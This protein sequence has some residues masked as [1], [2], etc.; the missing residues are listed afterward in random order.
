MKSAKAASPRRHTVQELAI[1]CAILAACVWTLAAQDAL[2]LARLRDSHAYR[3][4]S[5]NPDPTSNDDS[6]RPIPGE[7]IVL[8]DVQG[9][10]VI[11]HIWLTIAANEYGWPRLLRLRAYYDGS[12]TP[13]VDVPVGDFFAVGHGYEREVKSLMI[14][15]GSA[16]RARNSYWPMPFRRSC[17]ITITNEGRRR[18]SN[19]YYHV[20]WEKRKQMPAD[21]GYFHAW[22]KQEIPA[23]MGR[24][25]EVLSVRGRGQYVG[26]LLNVI[27]TQP[28][29]FGEGD[30]R[31]Y[32]D[33]EKKPSIEGTG[34]EDYFNDAWS[35]RVS[36]GPYWGVP[37]AEGTGP[38]ARMTAYRWHLRDPIPFQR[39][40][41][42][43][44]EHAGWT[45]NSNGSVKSAFEER[46]DIFSSVAFW[47][48]DG[49]GQV[50]PEPPYGS[51]RLPHGNALQIEAES[52]I[53]AVKTEG[54]KAEVQKDVFWSRDLLF[55]HATGAG[56]RIDVPIDVADD[57]FFEI[58]AQVAHAPDYGDYRVLLDGATL[59][60]E[61]DLEN[62]PGANTGSGSLIQAWGPEIYVAQDHLLGW[63]KLSKGTHTLAFVCAGKDVRSSGF[64]LGIDT[65]ILAKIGAPIDVVAPHVP[66]DLPGLI[67]TLSNPDAVF[68]GMAALALR[69]MGPAARPALKALA[70]ALRDPDTGVRMTAADAIARQGHEAVAVLDDLIA[71]AKVQGENVHVQRS[72]AMAFG[73]IGPAA[74]PAVPVLHDL[75]KI[76]RVTPTAATAIRQITGTQ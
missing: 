38:G 69:D 65:F 47:Y 50:L 10:G 62:E 12:A 24:P 37:V 1:G 72:L 54:G 25:Y 73:A 16:G 70:A 40:L 35:L 13:S 32:I 56:S 8:A 52:N 57:G 46:P 58:V 28:G 17:K 11:T 22:Y 9:P 7:T 34:T 43:D 63:R 44:F 39:S 26:T 67:V 66:S 27:Q 59:A 23:K 53:E 60:P 48:Q 3:S 51:A 42:F 33:G 2:D 21:I 4:S 30:D 31:F 76:P 71:A 61:G 74:A 55:F 5:N 75:E 18:V 41:R 68:R 6:R 45:Y 15:D 14:V 29:W 49:I 19:L 64:N 36:E 20:D